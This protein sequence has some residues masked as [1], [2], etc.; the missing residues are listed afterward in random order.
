MNGIDIIDRGIMQYLRKSIIIVSILL[1]IFSIS[2]ICIRVSEENETS[3]NYMSGG[4]IHRIDDSNESDLSY[5]TLSRH[6]ISVRNSRLSNLNETYF[7]PSKL[8]ALNN[9]FM[10]FE[11]FSK[12]FQNNA[13]PSKLIDTPLNTAINYYSVLQQAE[14]LTEKIPGGCGTIGYSKAP[15]PIAYNFLSENNKKSMPY[16]E[17]LAS[18]EG[19][20]HINLVKIIPVT[21]DSK[22]TYKFF[23]ELEILEGSDTG[24]TT[25]NYYTGELIIANVN[26]LYYVDSQVLTPED[27][28]CS[29]YHGWAHNAE[30]YVEIVYGNWCGLIMKQYSPQQD[31]YKKTI[32]IDGTDNKKYMFEF[33][34]LTNG[35]DMLINSLV[36]NNNE[37]VPVEIDVDKCVE[38]NKE[39]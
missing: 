14:N 6:A 20:G 2:A 26:G 30:T 39:K 15:Y 3:E 36:K 31:D 8:N 24:V 29:A 7:R 34:K 1:V 19:I 35:T 22:D 16:S 27:F 12:T 23:I 28:F 5:T 10:D 4:I 11:I 21:T 38:K 33:A 37:W 9:N 18:F 13:V 25:F 32:I 17:Y